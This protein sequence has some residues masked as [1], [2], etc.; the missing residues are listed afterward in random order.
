MPFAPSREAIDFYDEMLESRHLESTR[1]VLARA[2]ERHK[3]LFGTRPV[4]TVLRPA[5]LD[6]AQ[7]SEV[8]R[9]SA[10][11]MRGI[12]TLG[13]R[14]FRDPALRSELDLTPEEEELALIP[15]GYGAPD[16]SAR[17]DG[18]LSPEGRF[19]FVE[20]NAESPG[21]LAY[22]AVLGEAFASMPVME[23]FAARYDFR[24][25]P[26]RD[27]VFESLL[28]SYHRWG[29]RG[30]PNIAI[31]DW[32]GVSTYNEFLLMKEYFEAKG[33]RVR[34]GDPDELEYG[35]GR[36]FLDTFPVD[37]VYKRV[38]IGEL[39][40]KFGARHP[41][42]EAVRD[43]AV[44]MANGFGVQMLYKK[45]IFAMLS[46][47]SNR[48]MFEPRV[49]AALA[50]HIPWT[51]KVR[52]CVTAYR[53]RRVDL[54]P[55]I[56]ENRETLVLKPNGEYGGRGV[57][58]GWECDATTWSEA[59]QEGLAGS[60]IVQERVPLGRET[61]PSIVDGTLSFDERYLDLDPYVWRGEHVD[62]CGV[63]LSSLAL[64]NVSAGGG[65]A[66]PLFVIRERA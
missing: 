43:G 49:A 34:I 2:T 65:S 57:V 30:L 19:S 40:A 48:Q 54:L 16:V 11:V 22:G 41:L 10:L 25:L 53:E 38:V 51:R 61:F 44:C 31:V 64:L 4:C 6:E 17:L 47:D 5:F 36:L 55:F 23:E 52:E 14:L 46:D 21:G 60:Y 59:L 15:S 45:G 3:L 42:V 24:S 1:D 7:Y 39:L 50:E 26:V 13:Q 32:R 29:G 66:T 33:C 62:G 28:D 18:F 56:E 63:R 8:R 58:L 20:Y 27:Y 12:S 9:T 37:L 35:N